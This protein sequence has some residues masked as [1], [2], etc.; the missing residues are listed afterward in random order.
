MLL[1]YG[2]RL[3][4]LAGFN[5]LVGTVN[6]GSQEAL[7]FYKAAAESKVPHLDLEPVIEAGEK[8]PPRPARNRWQ[9]AS[10]GSAETGPNLPPSR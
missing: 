1:G 10:D 8:R 6:F 7:T 2:N 3:V 4:Q 9:P 5:Q